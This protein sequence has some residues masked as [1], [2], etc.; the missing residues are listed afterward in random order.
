MSINVRWITCYKANCGSSPYPVA[1]AFDDRCQDTHERFHCP[2]GHGQSYYGETK[3]EKLK[4]RVEV[5]QRDLDYA[6]DRI[7]IVARTC[8]WV[9]CDMILTN[10]QGLGQHMRAIHG[11]PTLAQI[12]EREEAA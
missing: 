6:R 2:Q 10:T 1:T 4:K 8:P 11:M 7:S 3:E 5:L 9:V 12:R